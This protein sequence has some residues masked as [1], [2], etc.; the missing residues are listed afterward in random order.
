[1]T[2]LI[3]GCGITDKKNDVSQS[4]PGY[5]LNKP[6][7]MKLPMELDEISGVAFHDSS[8]SIFAINDERGWLYKIR[9]GYGGE[10]TKWKFADGADFEDVVLLDSF[11]Y[12]LKS[13]G[14][15]ISF[16]FLSTDSLLLH[17][18]SFPQGSGNEFEILY[19]DDLVN[20]LV[21]ICKDCES[22]KK[23]ALST[24]TFDPWSLQYSDSSF[25][26]NV[27]RIAGMLKEKSIKFKP[28]AAAIHPITGELYIISSVNKLLVVAD[29]LGNAKQAFTLSSGFK[30]PE[31]VCFTPSGNMI[32]SNEAADV[33]VANI[34]IYT[35]NPAPK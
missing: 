15:I 26:I 28:S 2:L 4:P 19:Y 10:I 25:T 33:G 7:V 35:Y 13:N 29:R 23:K 31:G 21:L 24:F 34:L 3:A 27:E 14:N 30:Q 22:D 18:Y 12:V 8:K 32:V 9:A 5:N 11:F 1:M 20:K 16:R 6:Y 17:E